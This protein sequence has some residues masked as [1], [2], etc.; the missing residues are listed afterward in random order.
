M[1]EMLLI[2]LLLNYT[3]VSLN[4]QGCE[5]DK[6]FEITMMKSFTIKVWFVPSDQYVSLNSSD[7]KKKKKTKNEK[8]LLNSVL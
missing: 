4:S 7:L 1:A 6:C 8:N 3:G 2:P 5:A